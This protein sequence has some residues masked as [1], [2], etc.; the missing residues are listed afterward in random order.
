MSYIDI[1]REF[2]PVWFISVMGTGI[3]TSVL[4]HF[5]YEAEWLKVL[6]IIMFAICSFC[7]LMSTVLFFAK[8]ILLENKMEIMYDNK[9]NTFTG[10]YAMGFS[11]WVTALHLITKETYPIAIYSLWWIGIAMSVFTGWVVFFTM[12]KSSQ[13][14]I[15]EMNST[16]L[17]AVVPLSVVASQSQIILPSLPTH[18]HLSTFIVGFLLW[19][20]AMCIS[21]LIT[22]VYLH[23][24]L[25]HKL[26]SQAAIFTS[27]IPIG[28]LGQGGYGIQLLGLNIHNYLLALGQE[29]E[30]QAMIFKTLGLV[31]GLFLQSVGYFFTFLAIA[32]VLSYR[33][34]KFNYGF[35]AMTFPLG[36]MCLSALQTFKL[37]NWPA[38]RIISTVY[39]TSLIL[40][41]IFCLLA[42]SYLMLTAAPALPEEQ[43]SPR[44]STK[45][46][47]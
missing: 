3:S 19:S 1:L 9:I 44:K 23:R 15:E 34:Q 39:G 37:T 40:I 8:I 43:K 27:F 18:L 47:V 25:F 17:L 4:F 42:S 12:V 20:N 28:F 36:T 5:P 24:L 2:K 21:F 14:K 26:P 16:V 46:T 33:F 13:L 6:S 45:E 7:L 22:A 29:N 31:T 41:T 38:F 10:C 11:S 32:S 30:V 35:W